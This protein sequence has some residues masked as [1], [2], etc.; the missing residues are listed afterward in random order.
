MKDFTSIL[1]L[2]AAL[3]T[4][5]LTS[6]AKAQDISWRQHDGRL[7]HEHDD[8]VRRDLEI[9]QKLAHH[10][11]SGVRK[12]SGHDEGEKFFLHYWDFGQDYSNSS[13][14]LLGAPIAPHKNNETQTY[15][16]FGRKLLARDFECPGDTVS[17]SSI[18]SNLCCPAGQTCV[19]VSSGIGCCPAGETCGNE[20][21]GCN[22]GGGY[23]SCPESDNGGCC[24]PGAQCEGS[25]CIFYGTETVTATLPTST[26]T[27]S[28][29]SP[30]GTSYDNGGDTAAA[31]PATSIETTVATSVQTSIQT[32]VQTSVQTNVETNEYT[33]TDTVTVTQSL[34][35]RVSTV[36]APTTVVIVRTTASSQT[37][38]D[39]S[40][41]TTPMPSSESSGT[42]SAP[43]RPTSVTSDASAES[44]ATTTSTSPQTTISNAVEACPTGYYMCSAYYMGGCCRVGRDCDTTSCPA[45]ASTNVLTDGPT[46]VV[47]YTSTTTV[48]GGAAGSNQGS[49]ASGWFACGSD[50]GGGCCPSG[51]ACGTARCSATVSGEDGTTTAKQTVARSEAEVVRWGWGAGILALSAGVGMVV[52]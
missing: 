10:A 26:I 37:S 18:G 6:S 39:D 48:G 38:E 13:V 8:I 1:A 32:S 9:E 21:G 17:C 23:T 40:T 33:T 4:L 3:V 36:T 29:S 12:M 45:G 41:T 7:H 16:L 19:E 50:D 34:S 28:E 5:F 27:V 52:L 25:G 14:Q 20:V 2:P 15:G 49:C 51:F 22:A 46:V 35:G 42:A 30:T 43:I 31:G 11:P 44:G 47:P 24:V